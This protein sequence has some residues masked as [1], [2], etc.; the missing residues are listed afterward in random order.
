MLE[1]L[2]QAALTGCVSA[3]LQ[4]GFAAVVSED[5]AAMAQLPQAVRLV[6]LPS[7][8][9]LLQKQLLQPEY[10]ED[11]QSSNNSKS[12]NNSKSSKS[13]SIHAANG[14]SSSSAASASSLS[15]DLF[16]VHAADVDD[17]PCLAHTRV[18]AGRD[19]RA[20]RGD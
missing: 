4:A 13:S 2:R 9:Q 18:S 5:I 3:S 10:G 16:T 15:E 14:S 6:L 1:L 12:N 8:A 7:V 11:S 20:E 17:E 19:G